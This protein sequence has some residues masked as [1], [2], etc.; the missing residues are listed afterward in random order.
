[1]HPLE[2]YL[3]SLSLIHASG[4]GVAETSFYPPLAHLLDE[5]GQTLKPR[6]RCILNLKNIGAG[7]PDG[8]LTTDQFPKSTS[9][10]KTSEG[11]KTS[12]VY[13]LP[14]SPPS[15]GA[16]EIKS[17]SADLR[18]TAH[19]LQV[20]KYLTKYHQVLVTN[21]REFVLMGLDAQGR[22]VEL[23]NYT[24]APTEAGFWAD[25]VHPRAVVQ[26]HGDRLVDFFKRVMRRPAPLT[27]PAEV[28]WFLASY[29]REAHWRIEADLA[30]L[31]D[32]P[33]LAAESPLQMALNNIRD[34]LEDALGL[35][36][37]GPK[38]ER[39]FRS[40]LIQT[41][42]Y[43]IFS[44][45]V[46]WHNENPARQDRFDWRVA[47]WYLRVPMIQALFG[48]LAQPG[49][50]GSQ[51]LNLTEVLQWT[52]DTLNRVDRAEF[53]SRFEAGQAIQYFYEPFLQAFSPELRK[54]LGVWY[55]PPEIVQYMVARVDTVLREE[56]GL[57]DGLADEQVYVLDPCCGTGAYLVEVLRRIAATKREQGADAL[58]AYSVKKAALERVFG[59]EIMPAPFVIAHLQLGLLFQSLGAPLA[60][61]ERAGVYLTNALTGWT[62]PDHPKQHLLLPALEAERDAA[63]AV[64]QN[65]KIL[66]VLGNPPYNGYA[67]LAVAEER[68]LTDAYRTTKAAPAPQGQGL[69]DL[70]VRFF[71]LAERQIVERSGSGVVCYISN[72]SW[73]DG[74]SHTGMRERY[75]ER[76]D[77]IWIDCLNGDKFKTGKL[78]PQG[79]P[80][81]SVFSTEFNREGIG[82]GTAIALLARTSTHNGTDKVQFRHFWGKNKRQELLDSLHVISSERSEREIPPESLQSEASEGFLAD[83]RNDMPDNVISSER[84]EREI[85]PES[86]ENEAFE[87]FLA[88]ARNDMH[89]YQE[90][91][92]PLEL[93]LPYMPMQVQPAYLSWPLLADLFPT[94]SPGVNT[95]RDIDLIEIDRAKLERRMKIY[96]DPT[97]GDEV[98]SKHAPSIMTPTSGYDP[99]ATRKVLLTRGLASGYFIKYGYRPFDVRYLYWHP[100]TKLLDRNREDLFTAVQANNVL[101][102]SRKKAER[103]REGTPFYISNLLADRHLTRPGSACFPLTFKGQSIQ[104]QTLFDN[105]PNRVPANLSALAR[106]YLAAIGIDDPEAS[107]ETASLLGWHALAIGYSPEYLNENEGALRQD[108]PRIPLPNTLKLLQKS[109]ALGQ[110]IAALLDVEKPVPGVTAGQIRPELKTVGVISRVGGGS[111]DPTTDLA[112]TAGWGYEGRDG[113]TMPGQGHFVER[114]FTP[115]ERAAL[116]KGAAALGLSLDQLA[117]GL[118][119]MTVDV[120]LNEAAY[121]ANI[122]LRAWDYTIGGYQVMKKWLSYREEPILG[123]SLHPEEA[124]EVMHMA[125]R[126]LAIVLLEAALNANYRAVKREPYDY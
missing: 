100:E 99:L 67:G 37:E 121:W 28:A 116:E 42:F 35:T 54:E 88:T 9:T 123:R 90:I 78:T 82:I 62:P 75:L 61:S 59:F 19:G 44:A 124:Y 17:A 16:I 70:Y 41:L 53:F 63:D 79:E 52:G 11:S 1:M 95:S 6:V 56:L 60:A 10:A 46:L 50:I 92:P 34:A 80:D 31:K 122:P 58:S 33:G 110:K 113:V 85:P 2:T 72:Y 114:T 51:G 14:S 106:K 20:V 118:S 39:F 103:S 76:F 97:S 108:W 89:R 119:D 48:Q 105:L 93:G 15:R 102:I 125:R 86:L 115:D 8:G 47:A 94:T 112:V 69:N 71:R 81:P 23:E 5:V 32:L 4:A 55:T 64:K 12:E 65:R 43:G 68:D 24:L 25:T 87:G 45:W 96:F 38:G 74:L 98:V 101:L 77:K 66:V 18:K 111:L 3:Q 120:S 7:L 36:F 91:K 29:A 22:P 109:A 104:Q 26:Q 73:L 83:A 126:I 30:G 57:A 107:E 40:T 21:Y 27:T 13:S 117:Q 49:S 84:S